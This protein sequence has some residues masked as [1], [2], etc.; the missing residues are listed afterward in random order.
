MTTLRCLP[1]WFLVLASGLALVGVS[2][3]AAPPKAPK[4]DAPLELP[5]GNPA[6]LVS[7]A[8]RSEA[9]ADR[10]IAGALFTEGRLLLNRE[11]KAGALRKFERAWRY[12]PTAQSL[13]RE[14]VS[15]AIENRR[16]DE[17]IRYALLTTDL[18]GKDTLLF[19]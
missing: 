2:S 7:K 16:V 8:V 14:I 18:Q 9:E 5:E 19:R 12:D 15:L 10:L 13:L 4:S 3:Q 6:P 17:A 11:D 1:R